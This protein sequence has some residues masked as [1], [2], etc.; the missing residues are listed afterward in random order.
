MKG[1]YLVIAIAFVSFYGY[2]QIPTGYYAAADGL[3]G[4][5][6][7]AALNNII[8]GHTELSYTE[9]KEALKDTD[10]DPDNVNN[11]ICLYT[12][13][14]YA[15]TA[16]G[17]GSE[18][19]NREHT[20]SK[21]H[22]DFGDVAPAGTDIHHLR[23]ADASVNSAKN[24]RDF[25]EGTT[26]YIDASGAT[27]CYMSTDV[28][29][30]RDAVKGDVA[31]M[32]FYM[33]TRYEG[34]NGEPD[35][36]PVDYVNTAPSNEPYY[37]KLSTLLTWH[38]NDPVDDWERNRNDI[39]YYNYQN[40]RNPFIDHPEYV[41]SIW[42]SGSG[43]G[44]G[45]GNEPNTNLLISEVAD[46]ANTANAKFVEIYN[47]GDLSI[48]FD[49]EVWYLSR[50]ANAGSWVDLKLSGLLLAGETYIVSYN[51]STFFT[52]YGFNADANSTAASGNG[53][54]GYFL[55]S[56]G[57]HTSG[58][59]IDSFGEI[60]VDGI[61]ED[62]EYTDTKAVRVYNTTE[63][64]PVWTKEEWLISS[65]A[66]DSDMSPD[67]HHKTL[68]WTGATSKDWS[69]SSNWNESGVA[70]AFA[71]D[72]GTKVIVDTNVE[73]VEVS[74]VVSCGGIEVIQTGNVH[75]LPNSRLIVGGQN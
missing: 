12:G 34:E 72:A 41:D 32:I 46:P 55:F 3:T 68:M 29:E 10:E 7:K 71:P 60:D 2:S 19:W 35:L 65:T 64:N 43:G 61:G 57:G 31:R 26:E 42:G 54:D 28:W 5:Q 25:D 49:S 75:L 11:V 4:D 33:A 48:D 9:A 36:E 30:P 17:N 22:G 44:G 18:E 69:T 47:N 56:G 16:F 67:W 59:L 50:Q 24:N 66:N 40:N 62:W 52:S 37:G 51:T 1:F 73:I 38:E 21:S 15:K 20:W 74:G 27:G 6:L 53:N 23:P 14:S 63:P 13:W 8:D 70:S 45:G 39:I 58:T